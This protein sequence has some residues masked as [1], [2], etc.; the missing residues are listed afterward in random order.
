MLLAVAIAV[1]WWGYGD[2]RLRQA[3]SV[4]LR[5][6]AQH[7]PPWYYAQPGEPLSGPT[8]D[9]VNEAA[10][11][12]G[13]RIRWVVD[14]AGP[15]HALGAGQ[16]DIWP[17]A[18]IVPHR[19]AGLYFTPPWMDL[20]YW[21]VLN[22]TKWEIPPPNGEGLVIGVRD[23]GLTRLLAEKH[24]SKARFVGFPSHAVALEAVC[25][26][27]LPAA[28]I[29]ESLIRAQGRPGETSC[30]QAG[31]PVTS[32]PVVT[33]GFGVAARRSSP[34][35]MAAASALYDE[36]LRLAEDGTLTTAMI[37]WGLSS[38]EIRI[39]H[40][41]Y[42]ARRAAS[43]LGYLAILLL[44]MLAFL[45][46]NHLSLRSARRRLRYQEQI[47]AQS[48]DAVIASDTSSRISFCNPAA[49]HLL[50]AEED[51]LIGQ[52]ANSLPGQIVPALTSV[53][54]EPRRVTLPGRPGLSL[55]VTSATLRD[56][57]R[58]PIGFVATVRDV[59]LT[60]QLEERSRE[61]QRIES[62]GI[63]AG[64]IAHNFNNLLTVIAG[65]AEMLLKRLPGDN[66]MAAPIR[67]VQQSALEATELTKQ[68]LAFGRRQMLNPTPLDM[69]A[70][71]AE[72]V[73]ML[74][75]SIDGGIEVEQELTSELPQVSADRGQLSQALVELALY[76]RDSM[77]RG[78]RLTI[79]TALV[80]GE[81]ETSTGEP[82]TPPAGFVTVTLRD[83][84]PG[85]DE[86]TRRRV[87]DPFFTTKAVGRGT[88]LGLAA[89]HGIVHQSGGTISVESE[90]G[91][92][93]AFT[94]YF[95]PAAEAEGLASVEK[96]PA[97]SG[98]DG[99][100]RVLI[101]DDEPPVLEYL[102]TVLARS[103]HA[104]F[105][106][107]GF[108]PAREK[109]EAQ[110]D[111]AYDLLV[112]DVTMPEGSGLELAKLLRSRNPQA[113]VLYISGFTDPPL[114]REELQRPGVKFLQKP[115]NA[116]TLLGAVGS[117]SRR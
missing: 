5:V 77:P 52:P 58:K 67:S 36:I 112:T 80:S 106:A 51:S 43:L 44:L 93:T 17:L 83:T 48:S 89:V 99:R 45:L 64:G 73:S 32:L 30:M 25:A 96:Q 10:R 54:N 68:L 61:A 59:T 92:G 87:F 12:I 37:R 28:L 108:E 22:A 79:R 102:S 20:P 8:C 11:R 41:N 27:T 40:A 101:V 97:P 42:A 60:R 50:G 3:R 38:A 1:G 94:L 15:E 81:P 113:H 55:E 116:E 31:I 34:E 105:S 72:V 56:S 23:S 14:Q 117:M 47:L 115:F 103:G 114:L 86:M 82:R 74:Q 33:V 85:M 46:R 62:L 21:L 104:V 13:L 19:E 9:L 2:Y 91:K 53:V 69:N 75:R 7:S 70:V 49:A 90:P 18:G 65:W 6:G 66:W 76:A 63:L 78:G 95:P 29:A 4:V 109:I 88:G 35:A 100:R 107:P 57:K 16:A 26:G 98:S 84:G 110:E 71:V 111:S 39:Q 24:F